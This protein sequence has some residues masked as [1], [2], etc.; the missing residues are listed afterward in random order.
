[1]TPVSNDDGTVT[2]QAS[3]PDEVAIVKWT[4][5]VGLTLVARDRTRI[6]LQGPDGTRLAFEF[7]VMIGA[8]RGRRHLEDEANETNQD[9]LYLVPY[10]SLKAT[11]PISVVD[12]PC[13]STSTGVR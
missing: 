11:A 3:S 6:E 1:M 7:S 12:P 5:S 4:E 9:I 13:N 8:L 10:Y 2:Y